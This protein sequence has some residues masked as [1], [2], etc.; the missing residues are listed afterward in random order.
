[1]LG[2]IR[3]TLLAQ[4]KPALDFAQTTDKELIRLMHKGKI[5]G[6]AMVLI[7]DTQQVIRYY[8]YA[9]LQDKTPV[10][11]R[12]LFEI[13]SCTKAFTAL[14][15]A[16]LVQEGS[17]KLDDPVTKYLPWFKVEYKKKSA[18]V[19]IQ[20]LLHHTS[21][22]PWHTI[23]NIKPL[24][25][26]DALEKTVR[27]LIGQKLEHRPGKVFEY[28]TINYDA[29][30]LVIQKVSKQPFEHYLQEQ[31]IDPLGLSNTRIGQAS[32]P[33]D[34]AMGHKLGFFRPRPYAAPSFAGNNAAGYVVSNA[35]DMAKWL[36]FQMGLRAS[37]LYDL[38]KFT[39]QRDERVGLH[40]QASYAA[41]WEISLSGNGE[42]NH[43]GYN[44]A[45]TA[46]VAFQ[47]QKRLGLVLLSNTASNYTA[48]IGERMMKVVAAEELGK[49]Y[50]PGDGG[51]EA[52]SMASVIL[53]LFI[54]CVCIYLVWICRD[55]FRGKRNYAG[56]HKQLLFRLFYS[57][58]IP[59]PFL[60]ALY[61]MPEAM[62]G[63][64]WDSIFVWTPFSLQW[65]LWLLGGALGLG[66]LAYGVSM[67]FP[68]RNKFKGKVPLLLLMGIMAGLCNMLTI[69]L[70]TSSLDNDVEL[71]YLIFFYGIIALFYLLG[72]RYVQINLIRFSRG[73]TYE[74]REQLLGKIMSTSY[75]RFEK[76]EKG[77]IY[78]AINDDIGVIGESSNLFISLVTS[79]ITATGA[80]I[81]LASVAFWA[82]MITL[83]LIF[84]ITIIYYICGQTTNIYFEQARDTQNRFMTLLGGMVE[85]FKELSLQHGKKLE[86]K[87]EIANAANLY[88]NK[89]VTASIRFVNVFLIGESLLIVLLGVVAF[90]FPKIFPAIETQTI[91]NF[92]VI[93]LYLIGPVNS[94]L[95]SV[96][97]IIQVRVSWKRIKQFL[98]EIPAN[99]DLNET[100]PPI[101]NVV[102]NIQ[103]KHLVFQYKNDHGPF[104]VGPIS[105]EAE[106]GEIVFIIGGNGSG[107][108]TLAKLLL[109]LYEPDSGEVR[110]NGK[111]VPPGLLGEYFSAAFSPVFLFE[112]IYNINLEGREA[113]IQ[114][115]LRVLDLEDKVQISKNAFSTLNLSGGQRKRLALLLCYLEDAPIFLFDE[116]AAD[117][118]PEYRKFFYR[119]LLPE[120]RMKGKIVIAI[121]HDDHYFDVADKIMK[122]DQGKLE[123]YAEL[124]L[125][126]TSA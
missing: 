91:R 118:D 31:V 116:W 62:A 113:E 106:Q 36:E 99:L 69:I 64:N 110:V 102:N 87:T 85:G 84:L 122:M 25:G 57:F 23:S 22:I 30:A 73:A 108:T 34:K 52:Y 13:G 7:K 35:T 90:G 14:A 45:F 88:R 37:P 68:D 67:I 77:R 20:Q 120:M 16:K 10:N 114:H 72:R 70:I 11:Q 41:G 92:I 112:K 126:E 103:I 8:G 104:R 38:A 101:E 49:T 95:G 43:S 60:F 97:A 75:Q 93:L 105:F 89:I 83:L 47:P 40:G 56:L 117:Q 107:K 94:I 55:I 74:L 58:L 46:Y 39:H 17:I 5:P 29:L 50:D 109:G 6:L 1:M 18:V 71:K 26:R 3:P 59:V 121:T 96:P 4:S 98:T 63:F 2:F 21:G 28:A 15:L 86:Y 27:T 54:L 53:T 24:E 78:T 111:V 9:N 82:T 42:I 119:I 81:F 61:I 65:C 125:P 80:F 100:P 32:I 12:T 124:R 19:T 115:Y 44:P 79:I 33:Q 48:Y 123:H 66:M 76:I 51:D